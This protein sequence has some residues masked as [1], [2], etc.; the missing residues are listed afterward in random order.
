MFTTAFLD[1][2][3]MHTAH[4]TVRLPGSKSI[5]NRV[6]LLAGL[7]AGTTVLHDVLE[8][9]DT[10]VM[11]SALTTLGCT[12]E[13]LGSTCT[14]TGLGQQ[15]PVTAAKLFMG[16]A[17]TAMRPLAAVLAILAAV[18]GGD[19]ELFG[20]ARMHERPIGDLVTALRQLGCHIPSD[21]TAQAKRCTHSSPFKCEA[22]S[23]AS[24]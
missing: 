15:L 19:F 11:L 16:N 10:Q 13:R 1:L 3:P 22:M 5:S 6:L 18:H 12:V 21:S 4:G 2:P 7:S 9:D 20:V 23:L 14:I 8:S 17:G 24:F